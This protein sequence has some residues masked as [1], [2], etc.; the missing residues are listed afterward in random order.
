MK[1]IISGVLLIVLVCFGL[2]AC[3]KKEFSFSGDWN[4]KSTGTAD[5]QRVLETEF[6]TKNNVVKSYYPSWNNYNYS[7]NS[8]KKELVIQAENELIYDVDIKSNDKVSL[9]LKQKG[10]DKKDSRFFI[11]ETITLTRKE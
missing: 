1:K 5:S 3:G 11:P 8:D 4:L 2:S 9:E 7:Y 10:Q 6:D